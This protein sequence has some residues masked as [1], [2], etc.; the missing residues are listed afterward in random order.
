MRTASTVIPRHCVRKDENGLSDMQATLLRKTSPVRLVS[1]PTGAGKSRSYLNMVLAGRKILFVVP[2]QRLAGN[3]FAGVRADLLA[4]GWSE[5]KIG[6]RLHCWIGETAPG[7]SIA[8][9]DATRLNAIERSDGLFIITPD[10]LSRILQ[11]RW[12]KGVVGAYF[13]ADIFDEI[14]FDEFHL[15]DHRSFGLACV[16][17]KLADVMCGDGRIRLVTSFLSATPFDIRPVL[18]KSGVRPESIGVVTEV[19]VEEGRP[20]HG[21]VSVEA[22]DAATLLEIVTAEIDDVAARVRRGERVLI[23]YDS[24]DRLYRES[25]VL[26]D[27]FARH[28]LARPLIDSSQHKNDSD[29][30]PDD[31]HII[32]STSTFEMGLTVPGLS[33]AVLDPG[34]GPMNLV[35]RIGRVARGDMTGRVIVRIPSPPARSPWIDEFVALVSS[36]PRI[37]V[38]VFG[39]AMAKLSGLDRRYSISETDEDGVFYG[40]LGSNAVYAAALYWAVLIEN[41][42]H[43]LG[44]AYHVRRG[45][46]DAQP[47]LTRLVRRWLSL[48][49]ETRQGR[50]LAEAIKREAC[51]IRDIGPGVE[52][53]LANGDR[54]SIQID[55]LVRNTTIL[56]DCPVRV[57]AVTGVPFIE[58]SG[59]ERYLRDKPGFDEVLRKA[60]F[61]FGPERLSSRNPVSGWLMR[62]EHPRR[63]EAAQLRRSEKD[64]AAVD[65]GASLV[66][67]TGIV[68]WAAEDKDDVPEGARTAVL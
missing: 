36:A 51:H 26:E 64:R 27:L 46:I 41:E 16:F 62:S 30:A 8:E 23:L 11:K 55:W 31:A 37:P 54:K 20:L 24:L 43:G 19:L 35:Q 10:T 44:N 22:N 45:V 40:G 65:A 47:P 14:V 4:H 29:R 2:T 59:I 53:R 3:F 39:A 63:L 33:L 32:I 67:H 9:R 13:I 38:D 60:V 68:P 28:G 25:P 34:I 48:L 66:R 18:E 7:V 42:A 6:R 49:E 17:A 15:L 12:G 52:M 50:K 1:G 56:T 57:D 61:Y 21:D 5:E 58:A